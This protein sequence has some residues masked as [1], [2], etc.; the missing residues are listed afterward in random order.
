MSANTSITFSVQAQN[1]NKQNGIFMQIEIDPTIIDQTTFNHFLK[2][3]DINGYT[4]PV[5]CKKIKT[6][7]LEEVL[8]SKNYQFIK[9][10][11]IESHQLMNLLSAATFLV[12]KGLKLVIAAVY[13]CKIY[14]QDT[15][16]AFLSKKKELGIP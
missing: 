1:K 13:A 16:E 3:C 15:K 10:F 11:P 6:N 9:E 4:Q 5:V 2:F 7:N 14:F 12:C 8:D